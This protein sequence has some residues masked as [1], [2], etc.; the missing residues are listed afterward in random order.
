MEIEELEPPSGRFLF[1]F[2]FFASPSLGEQIRQPYGMG[3]IR[4]VSVVYVPIQTSGCLLGLRRPY[5]PAYYDC[6]N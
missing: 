4:G 6:T 5:H 1:F 2:L 3:G